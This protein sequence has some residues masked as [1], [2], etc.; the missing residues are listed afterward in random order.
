M[1]NAFTPGSGPQG[2]FRQTPGNTA[3]FVYPV[4]TEVPAAVTAW[5]LRLPPVQVG[6][7]LIAY[8]VSDRNTSTTVTPPT[9]WLL[10]PGTQNGIQNSDAA[11]DDIG[12]FFYKAIR[13]GDPELTATTVTFTHV[14]ASA[15][16][17][18][19]VRVT[20]AHPTSPINAAASKGGLLTT[21]HVTPSIT[22][23][24]DGCRVISFMAVDKT[25]S[26][27]PNN[28]WTPPADWSEL[29]D[30]E[31]RV[32]FVSVGVATVRQPV[33]GIPITGTWV[34]ADSDSAIMLVVA[35][36]PPKTIIGDRS[37]EPGTSFHPGSKPGTR[38]RF[39]PQTLSYD[40]AGVAVV[41]TL[42][43]SQVVAPAAARPGAVVV[44]S[45]MVADTPI[46][47][48]DVPPIAGVTVGP[49]PRP[50]F[51]AIT[52]R[53]TA[54]P[55]AG[56]DTPPTAQVY[57][58]W[59]ARRVGAVIINTPRVEDA[60][61]RPPVVAVR[62]TL[63][64]PGVTIAQH[65]IAENASAPLSYV[66]AA[67][68]PQLFSQP[69]IVTPRAEPPIFPPTLAPV[70]LIAVQPQRADIRS[71]VLLLT[72]STSEPSEHSCDTDRPGSGTTTRP[73]AG[74]TA[75]PTAT[76]LR[77]GSGLTTR[78]DSGDTDNLC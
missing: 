4:Q 75:R 53:S 65:S 66:I 76:T 26:T 17:A 3:H 57:T 21:S 40:V 7:T 43:T 62:P 5:T 73:G 12:W 51:V 6:H 33:A 23:T 15:G 16:Q 37:S 50:G 71:A 54:D 31:E 74:E 77:P 20:D 10:I 49:T 52:T 39:I 45:R 55:V 64:R 8:L 11:L 59:S 70:A 30:L 27:Q 72:R 48:F 22:P 1:P 38:F 60:S 14:S 18:I 69:W 41:D 29:V 35:L 47:S 13:A 67:P 25:S 44:L 46:V 28:Y 56:T 34:S 19:V 9:G 2:R 36:N 42:P 32:N 58:P 78:P 68:R 24:V 61:P 63:P